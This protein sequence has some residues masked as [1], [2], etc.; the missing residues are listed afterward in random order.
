MTK[1]SI[2]FE[3][4]GRLA[5]VTGAAS[6][7]GLGIATAL[8]ETGAEVIIV[9]LNADAARAQAEALLGAGYKATALAIDLRDEQSVIAGCASII[10]RHA[11]PWLLVNNAGLQDRQDFLQATAEEWDR[12]HSVNARG[13]YLMTRELAR[14]MIE[15]GQGG[16]IVNI[17]SAALSGSLVHGLVAYTS[18]KGSLLGL[19]QA[20]AFELAEQQITVNTILPGA[21]PTPGAI[22][23]TGPVPDGPA[24]RALPLGMC[25]PADIAAA[26]LFFASPAAC[27]VTNQV[28]A[29]DGGFSVT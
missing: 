10:S 7:I 5:V 25:E 17:A 2:S 16:R 12:M 4:A 8:A 9:D 23:A 28:L 24:R 27:R 20:T 29:V 1:Q 15:G 19:S 14:A 13:P 11:C 18:S 6:G 3:L 26:V 22:N 21:V